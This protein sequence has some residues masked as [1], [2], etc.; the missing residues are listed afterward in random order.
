MYDE[1]ISEMYEEE[2]N[3][4]SNLVQ[5]ALETD[6]E[7]D[8]IAKELIQRVEDSCHRIEVEEYINEF[9]RLHESNHDLEEELELHRTLA[10]LEGNK[11]DDPEY[12]ARWQAAENYKSIS[13]GE[14]DSLMSFAS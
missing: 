14:I 9:E 11:S 12:N 8:K 7:S 5:S 2:I 1:Y 4:L 13:K 3:R 10:K 6:V